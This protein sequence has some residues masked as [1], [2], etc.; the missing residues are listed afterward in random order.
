MFRLCFFFSILMLIC[1]CKEEEGTY[2]GGYYWIYGYGL[3]DMQGEEA[4]QGISEKW[5]IKHVAVG[6]CMIDSELEKK[7]SA[8]NKATYALLE[9]RYGKD[10]RVRYEKDINEF[11]LNKVDI[12]DVLIT[13]KLFRNKLKDYNIEID[14]VDKEVKELNDH[15][16]YEVVVFNNNLK[17][18][19]KE[20]F[21]IQVDIKNRKV[22]LIN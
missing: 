8:K 3:K 1:S 21:R 12:M 9:K 17:Y 2:S 22:N 6:G 7:V 5:K 16:L 14:G 10:W 20:C 4:T 19:N 15:G 13:N 11:I 18:E